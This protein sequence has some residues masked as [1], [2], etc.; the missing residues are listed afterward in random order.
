MIII[1]DG[2]DGCGKTEI[3]KGL[4]EKLG[5]PYYKFSAE[6]E[7]WVKGDFLNELRFGERRQVQL[8]QQIGMSAVID[9]GYPSEIVYSQVF[10]RETDRDFLNW[11]D[12]QYAAM[13]TKIILPRREDYSKNREDDIIPHEKL[14]EIHNRYIMFGGWT[15]CET[16]PI[17][18]DLHKNDLQ[19]EM[20]YLIPIIRGQ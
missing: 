7:N 4:S 5:I 17:N 2:P 20:D 11:V 3:A 1:L 15:R 12:E 8:F 10:K 9:R 13:G 14:Q 6:K 16:I 18:V 19:S